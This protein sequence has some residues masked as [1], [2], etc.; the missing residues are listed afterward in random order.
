MGRGGEWNMEYK[1]ELQR[2]LNLKKT[3]KEV[4]KMENNKKEVVKYKK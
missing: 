4:K 2:K 1:N 3:V